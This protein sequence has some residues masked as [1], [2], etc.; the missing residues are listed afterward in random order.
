[1]I[2][3]RDIL[4]ERRGGK[5]ETRETVNHA[6][7]V[8][9]R[10][11]LNSIKQGKKNYRGNIV[12]PA[13]DY[14]QE[15]PVIDIKIKMIPVKSMKWSHDITA[16]ADM[17]ELEATINYN[18]SFLPMAYNDLIAEIK[19][20][21][22]HELEHVG[23]ENY[24]GKSVTYKSYE[25]KTHF[26]QYLLQANEVPAYV[27]GLYKRAKTKRITVPQAMEEWYNENKANF[28]N[29]TKDWKTVKKVW[30]EWGKK[31]LPTAQWSEQ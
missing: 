12:L 4:N 29:P 31:N 25:P 14:D 11:L 13:R 1:M 24:Q 26:K 5:E 23:Q 20:M 16:E 30:M 19:E 9:S 22:R 6:V 27:Q 28:K 7:L 15:A 2:K 3:L 10:D 17:E 8:I 21:L 18:P